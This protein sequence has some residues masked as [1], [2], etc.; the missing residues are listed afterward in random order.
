MSKSMQLMERLVD[1]FAEDLELWQRD[2][3]EAMQ[4]MDAENMIRLSIGIFEAIDD[5]CKHIR[6]ECERALANGESGQLEETAFLRQQAAQLYIRLIDWFK[7]YEEVIDNLRNKGFEVA[8]AERFLGCLKE[9]DRFVKRWR[10]EQD[11]AM[12]LRAQ[13]MREAGMPEEEIREHCDQNRYPAD[14]QQEKENVR[15]KAI[16]AELQPTTEQWQRIARNCS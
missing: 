14:L 13:W 10:D 3:D 5:T 12:K 4:Y 2:H 8:G 16:L 1:A 6:I 9:A 7:V 11:E 15:A